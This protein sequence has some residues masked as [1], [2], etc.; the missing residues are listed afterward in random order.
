M[1]CPH[2]CENWDYCPDCNGSRSAEGVAAAIEESVEAERERCARIAEET[3]RLFE[4]QTEDDGITDAGTAC[5]IV[6][7]KIREG[8]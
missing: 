4:C 8:P 2:G 6:A 5:G 3:A 1:A 7:A